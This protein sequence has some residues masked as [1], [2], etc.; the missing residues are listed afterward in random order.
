MKDG[1]ELYQELRQHYGS[2]NVFR[3]SLVKSFNYTEGVQCFAQ[4]A[5][6]GAYWLL[7]IL[8]TEPAIANLVNEDGFALVVFKV[9]GTKGVLTVAGDDGVVPVF[10]REMDYTDCPEAPE[11]EGGWKFYLE[12]SVVGDKEVVMCMLPQER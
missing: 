4:R 3:H 11:S 12:P 7:D 10:T 8:A 1:Q 5:G 2:E 6:N 9:T